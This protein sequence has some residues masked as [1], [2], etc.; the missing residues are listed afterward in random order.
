ML[1]IIYFTGYAD[2]NTPFVVADNIKD[3]IRSLEEVGKN[4]IIWFSKDEMKLNPDKGLFN[5][6]VTH[7]VWAGLSVFRD[8]VNRLGFH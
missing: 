4:L 6:Y 3:V 7:R 1:N 2:D 8:V 5:N